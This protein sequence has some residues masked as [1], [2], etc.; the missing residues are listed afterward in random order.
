MKLNKT[1]WKQRTVAAILVGLL[2]G[3]A[4]EEEAVQVSPLPEVVSSFTPT[5]L[6]D[7]EV[8]N[9]V[10]NYYSKL[11]PVYAYDKI[12]VAAREGEVVALSPRSGEVIWELD[13]SDANIFNISGGLTAS[14]DKLYFGTEAGELV[15]I[16]AETGDLLWRINA[17]GEILSKPLADENLI[18]V[19]TSKGDLAAFDGNNG[20]QRWRVTTDVPNLTLRGDSSPTSA[21]G[22][23]FW[24]MAN[25]R[26]GAAFIGN[27]NVIWQQPIGMPKGASEIDR[28]VDIDSKPLVVGTTLFSIG[29]NGQLVAI[30]LRSG[31]AIWKRNYSG[32]NDLAINGETLYFAND[33]DVVYAIDA[34]SGTELWSNAALK[35]RQLTAPAVIDGYVVFGDAEG[36]LHWLDVD[37]G[38]FVAQ[39]EFDNSG[40]AVPP[41]KVDSHF[42]ATTRNGELFLQSVNPVT[43]NDLEQSYL[44]EVEL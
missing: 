43:E 27:G 15:A 13:L 10:E 28:L 30:D 26:L 5:E 7:T 23:V 4:G 29:Y 41:I 19:H 9:G 20:E 44:P 22:G 18:I 3:C 11:S 17:G 16:N 31:R 35:H 14:Y 25:G 40:F 37:S 1:N 24:G 33:Q 2:A 38:D 6:W 39:Q 21:G 8:G 42:L 34:R 36:Y 12:F 32:T